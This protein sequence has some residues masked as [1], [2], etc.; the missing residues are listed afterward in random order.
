MTTSGLLAALI[1]GSLFSIT[2]SPDAAPFDMTDTT[3]PPAIAAA[4]PEDTMLPETAWWTLFGDPILDACVITAFER[5][6]NL[7]MAL[8]R[9][10]QTRAILG[11]T[12]SY[13]SPTLDL[14]AQS[15]RGRVV[16]PSIGLPSEAERNANVLVGSI[17]YE[18]DLFGR[19]RKSTAAARADWLATQSA[20]DNVRLVLAFNVTKAYFNLRCTD[21]Q[22]QILRETLTA[23]QETLTILRD[24]YTYGKDSELNYQR[25]L[26]ETASV[27]RQIRAYENTLSQNETALLV[28]LGLNPKDMLFARNYTPVSVDVF[29]KLPSLPSG[30]SAE[31]LDRRPDLMQ[32]RLEYV[33][34]VSRVGK[35]EADRYPTLSLNVLLGNASGPIDDLFK[36]SSTGWN[37]LGQLTAP[38]FDAGRRKSRLQ[39]AEAK[40]WET[41]ANYEQTVRVALRE[42]MDALTNR[43]KLAAQAD[44][45]SIINNA[46]DKSYTLAI[47]QFQA[48]KVG[49]LDVLDAHRNLL[50]VRLDQA[51][52]KRD[53]LSAAAHLCMALGGGWDVLVDADLQLL[54][55][56]RRYRRQ[57]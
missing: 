29:P 21:E 32:A 4:V 28:L 15:A 14:Q 2:P 41:R 16:G 40:A 46:Q 30:L 22:L 53:Q 9:V 52:N 48:G 47:N 1:A 35:A 6:A 34:A 37:I 3:T 45:L 44:Q 51:V 5:N 33:A 7:D 50:Q 39:Q 42:I 56:K 12:G 43:E 18:A 13:Q 10:E 25:F 24:R 31:V 11:E 19:L 20:R 8:A 55:V 54:P 38:I 57:M 49:Q 17:N 26:A 36:S 23:D 27:E